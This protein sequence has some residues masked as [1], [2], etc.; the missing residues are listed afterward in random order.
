MFNELKR[1]T[2]VNS[3]R[4]F[5]KF[6]DMSIKHLNKHTPIKKKYKRGNQMHFVTKDLS[7][8]IMKRSKLRNN[9]LKNKTDA[10]RML[11]KKQRNYCVSL[12]RKSKTNYYA[13]L[14][15]K[16]VSD[17]KLIWTVI[18]PSLSGKSCDKEQINLVEK[19]EILK[20]D[21]E[22]VEVLNNFFGNIVKNLE[23]NQYSNFDPVINNVKDPTLRA[24]LKYKDHPSI[25][26]IQNSYKNRIKFTFEEMDL[27]S[28]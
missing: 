5:E 24:I 19:G 16:K 23:I 7:K 12:L 17:N 20:T 9:Y 22:K 25:L 6:C 27:A 28:I 8:V 21:L 1:E 3:D 13:N 2:F 26:E 15:E 4:G 18:K 14:D 11:Y 10:S